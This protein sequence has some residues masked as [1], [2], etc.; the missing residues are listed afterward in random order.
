M[1]ARSQR[2]LCPHCCR[3]GR[4]IGGELVCTLCVK[5]GLRLRQVLLL[6]YRANPAAPRSGLALPFLVLK[7]FIGWGET[8]GIAD[9]ILADARLMLEAWRKTDADDQSE[10]AARE[11]GNRG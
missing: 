3:S 9:D 5:D 2:F 6:L 1:G 8:K 4:S 11:D 10:V 7:L